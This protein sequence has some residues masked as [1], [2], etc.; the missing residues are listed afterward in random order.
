[1]NIISMEAVCAEGG[2][3]FYRNNDYVKNN[4]LFVLELYHENGHSLQT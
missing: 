1:M 4:T 3:Y 2:S